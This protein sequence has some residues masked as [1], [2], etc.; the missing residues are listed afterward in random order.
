MT[1]EKN[2]KRLA[3]FEQIIAK[4]TGDPFVYYGRA[5]ELRSLDRHRESLDAFA[6]LA[7]RHP[8]YVPTYLMA[9]Q[10][11]EILELPD[12]ARRWYERGIERAAGKDPH[13]HSE[14]TTALSA[15]G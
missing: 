11:A 12:E 6:D 4:G 3:M 9:G 13:A 10:V 15:L 7:E 14:L 2:E 1:T 8:D 5:M